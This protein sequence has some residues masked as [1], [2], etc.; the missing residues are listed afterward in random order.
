MRV[1]VVDDDANVAETVRRVLTTAGWN[2]TVSGDGVD[3][4]AQASAEEFD[5][6]VLD[7]I[8]PG[9]NGFE[10][11]RELRRREVWTPVVMLS[12]K[13]GE[14]DQAEA[15][16]FGA[17]DYLV[18]P[19]SVVVLN[20]HLRAVVRRGGRERPAVL[21][22]GTLSL[23]PAQR[24]VT[25]SGQVITLTPREYSVLEHLMRR[26]GT[27]VSKHS[28]LQSVWDENY[29]GDEN[30]IE[31]YIGYLRRRIDQPFGVSSIETVR[32]AG[33]RLRED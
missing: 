9:L 22:A 19:F 11:V 17:D 12:A 21:T 33:Y 27:V 13:D 6:I 4:L 29:T 20:A 18:K 7:I 32:G 2:V 15:L 23:D 26:K 3:A 5:A 14:Y 16:D 10:V 8:L 1:L 28:I 30:I 24:V 25:R 31:V